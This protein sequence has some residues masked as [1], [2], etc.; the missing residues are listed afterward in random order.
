MDQV[1]VYRQEEFM[2]IISAED[3]YR[4]LDN[5]ASAKRR[6]SLG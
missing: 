1:N 5:I 3:T 4:T 2:E 6:L